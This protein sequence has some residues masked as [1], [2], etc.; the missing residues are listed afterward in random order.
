MLKHGKSDSWSVS[1]M[2]SSGERKGF[3]A[4]VKVDTLIKQ[5]LRCKKCRKMFTTKSRPV[6][7]HVKGRSNRSLSN[8]QALCPNCHE[9]KN[10]KE[11]KQEAERRR[12]AKKK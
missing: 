9:I 10:Q 1:E 12:K 2:S 11:A 4:G 8:C 5:K 3:T 6:F 7:D